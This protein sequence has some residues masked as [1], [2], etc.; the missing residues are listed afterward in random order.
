MGFSVVQPNR[1]LNSHVHLEFWIE[2]EHEEKKEIET[3]E[4][5]VVDRLRD[6]FVSYGELG[7]YI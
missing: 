1:A 4:E 7:V 3:R 2:H 6:C 5:R